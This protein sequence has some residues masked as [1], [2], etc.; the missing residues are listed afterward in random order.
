MPWYKFAFTRAGI[1]HDAHKSF[2]QATETA[3]DVSGK[4]ADFALFGTHQAQTA[5]GMVTLYY[6]SPASQKYLSDGFFMLWKPNQI[7]ETKPPREGLEVKVGAAEA[8]QLLD[9]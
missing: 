6:L 8:L 2:I 9:R 1:D 5:E 4:P 7:T 3:W